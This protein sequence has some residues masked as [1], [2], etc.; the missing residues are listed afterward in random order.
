MTCP[1]CLNRFMGGRMSVSAM[2]T[3]GGLMTGLLMML[4]L[5]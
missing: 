1:E 2:L 4:S 3:V 5:G